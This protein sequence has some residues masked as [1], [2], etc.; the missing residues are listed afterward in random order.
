MPAPLIPI[1]V[2]IGRALGD[3]VAE[4][5]ADIAKRIILGCIAEGMTVDA[6]V[7]RLVSL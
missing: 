4:N 6:A 1:A 2:T 7:P 3:D 5:S